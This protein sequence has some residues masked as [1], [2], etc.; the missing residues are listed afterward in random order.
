MKLFL[1]GATVSEQTVNK[2]KK[3][4]QTVPAPHNGSVS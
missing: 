3:G 1:I 2:L 4:E